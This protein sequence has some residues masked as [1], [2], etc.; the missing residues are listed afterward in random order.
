M[1]ES[2]GKGGRKASRFPQGLDQ[3]YRSYKQ[4]SRCDDGAIAE[5]YSDSI[6]RLL[7]DGWKSFGTLQVLTNRSRDFREFILKHIDETVPEDRLAKIATNARSD[8]TT[9]GRNL[10]LAIVKAIGK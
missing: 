6:T 2:R 5:G 7:A 4:F 1:H 3:I 10:C 8:C 9:G